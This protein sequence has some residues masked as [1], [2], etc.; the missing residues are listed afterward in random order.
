MKILSETL[1]ELGIAFALPINIK[2]ADGNLTYYEDCDGDWYKNEFDSS[3]NETYYECSDD[4]WCKKEYDSKGNVTYFEN[5][6]GYWYKKEYDSDGNMTYFENSDGSWYKSEYDSD[7]NMTYSEDS[8]GHWCKYKYNSDGNET[9]FEDSDG[10]QRGNP[11]RS[12]SHGFGVNVPE[13]SGEITIKMPE[14]IEVVINA[15]LDD[16]AFK[17]GDFIQELG[18]IQEQYFD[19]LWE[20]VKENDLIEGMDYENARDWLFDYCFNGWDNDNNGFD[21]TFSE[22]VAE[23]ASYKIK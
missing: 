14:P 15:E 8:H 18:K 20:K 17:V 7:G 13:N 21:L 4:Y 3:G 19:A 12:Q 2:D 6:D 23:C 22:T 10:N 5:N 1:K 11:P 9:Y 16:E